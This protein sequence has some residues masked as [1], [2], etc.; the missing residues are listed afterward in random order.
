MMMMMIFTVNRFLTCLVILISTLCIQL[1]LA[2]G[3]QGGGATPHNQKHNQNHLHGKA[4]WWDIA[5]ARDDQKRRPLPLQSN[6]NHNNNIHATTTPWARGGHTRISRRLRPFAPHAASHSAAYYYTTTSTATTTTTTTSAVHNN[7]NNNKNPQRGQPGRWSKPQQQL[8][9]PKQWLVPSSSSNSNSRQEPIQ[10]RVKSRTSHSNR[11]ALTVGLAYF[12]TAICVNLPIVLLPTVAAEQASLLGPSFVPAAFVAETLGG[13]RSMALYMTGIAVASWAFSCLTTAASQSSSSFAAC[14]AGMEFLWSIQWTACCVVLANHYAH[15]AARLAAAVTTLSLMST[16]G[17][18]LSKVGGTALLSAVGGSWR[19]VARVGSLAALTG[20]VVALG[21][22]QEAPVRNQRGKAGGWRISSSLGGSTNSNTGKRKDNSDG[23]P[24]TRSL[25]SVIQP[26][27]QVL[28]C[29]LF[30]LIGM[31]HAAAFLARTSDRVLCQFY[32]QVSGLSRSLCGGLTTSCTLGFVHG[33]ARG[34]VFHQLSTGREKMQFLRRNYAVA[35]ASAFGLALCGGPWLPNLVSSGVLRAA[36]VAVLSGA[37]TSCF[38]FQFYQ[39]PNLVASSP[40]FQHSKAMFISL[41][42]C[43]G[44]LLATP[45]WAMTGRMVSRFEHGWSLAWI[46][47]T[48][49]YIAGG[50]LMLR[51]V[52]PMLHNQKD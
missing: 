29:K 2:E 14:L 52:E 25:A 9:L 51:N 48:I 44:Y 40:Q 4:W 12:C 38:S 22:I 31:G 30:W 39:I 45:V 27:Q 8:P 21:W 17:T 47:L 5:A 37:M 16:A 32:V 1:T 41:I 26:S 23:T 34:R 43:L 36:L 15:D 28:G 20:A 46:L 19:I 33:L 13:R 10:H 6:N 7:N 11:M 18:I 3:W 24:P 50:H 35:A 42:D 49:L